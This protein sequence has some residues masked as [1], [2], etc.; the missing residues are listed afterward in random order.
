MEIAVGFLVLV[1][2]YFVNDYLKNI[3]PE[4][5]RRLAWYRISKLNMK[6]EIKE[7]IFQGFLNDCETHKSATTEYLMMVTFILTISDVEIP[8]KAEKEGR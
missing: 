3:C 8:K 6:Q 4:H 5:L 2:G 7:E 1:V